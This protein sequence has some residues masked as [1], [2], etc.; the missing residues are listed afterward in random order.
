M[1][2]FVIRLYLYFKTHK[3]QFYLLMFI[4]F[5]IFVYYGS[6]VEYEEDISKLLPSTDNSGAE[7]LAFSELKVK[8]KIFVLFLSRDS[9][10]RVDTDTLSEAGDLFVNSLQ[11]L[12][13]EVDVEDILYKIES[14]FQQDI[15]LY[16]FNHV[17]LFIDDSMYGKFDSILTPENIENQ[18]AENRMRISSPEGSLYYRFMRYDPLGMRNV[19][20]SSGN[21]LEGVTGGNYTL[22]GNHFFTPDT[23][24]AI[25]FISPDF[26]SFDSKASIRL[27]NKIEKAIETVQ[28]TYPE[29]EVLFH[30]PPVQSVFNSR[31]IKQD[32]IKTIGIAVVVICIIIMYC[33]RNKSTL[34]MLLLPIVYGTFFS[35]SCVYLIKGSMS[36]MALGIGAIVL[37][38]ALSYCLHILTHFKYVKDPVQIIRDQVKP[39]TLGILTTVGA[40]AVLLFTKSALLRDFGL[41]ASIALV[42]TAFACLIF[43]PQFFTVIESKRSEKAFRFLEEKNSYPLEKQYWLIALIVIVFVFGFFISGKVKFDS[44]LRNIGYFEPKVMRSMN[45]LAEKTNH[46][47]PTFYFAA[48]SENLDSALIKNENVYKSCDSLYKAGVIANFSKSATVLLPKYKQEERIAHWRNYW[49]YSKIQETKEKIIKAGMANGFK[50][51]MFEPFF[52]ILSAGYQPSS[53]FQDSIIPKGLMGNMIEHTQG[54]YLV[55][56][57]VQVR[58]ENIRAV[59]DVIASHKDVISADPFYYTENMVDVIHNDFDTVLGISSLLVLITLLVS[60]RSIP[61]A[62]IAFAPMLMSWY[63]VLGVMYMFGLEFNLINIVISTFIFG[64]GDDYSIFVLEGLLSGVRGKT[65]GDNNML[66]YHKTAIFLS[67]VVLVIAIASLLFATHP[68]ISSIGV[69]TLTGMCSTILIAYTLEPFLFYMMMKTPY[70]NVVRRKMQKQAC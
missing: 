33:F 45:L 40:F 48:I 49:T 62:L 1:T 23:S 31:Q 13:K 44:N 34:P 28:T 20:L 36:L 3:L 39:L 54:M 19:F 50:P 60:F 32:L 10:R 22:Y 58:P 55:Y 61:L 43:L 11:E 57:S 63:I 12:D 6:K 41:F 66:M 24:V 65:E 21:G 68:A 7:G 9:M 70:G 15:L 29:V 53:L 18:T 42:G 51:E 25:V 46:G 47:M 26:I 38:V 14:D 4:S 5:G 35:L 69:S 16:A 8:D 56:T 64:I 67:A 59:S 2:N 27:A 52:E 30:G 37:G 17:P